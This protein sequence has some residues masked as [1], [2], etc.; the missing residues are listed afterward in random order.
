MVAEAGVASV[1]LQMSIL[2]FFALIGYLIAKRIGQSVVVGE[3]LVG[4]I[5]G[6][7]LLGWVEVT[8]LITSLAT[9]GAIFLLFVVGLET[10]FEEIKSLKNF[11]IAL[12]GVVV[13]WIGG[14]GF[15]LFFG[16]DLV[17]SIFVGTALTATSIAI[18]AHVLKEK[19]K[20]DSPAA[21]TIIGA[22]V[23]DDVLSLVGLSMTAQFAIQGTLDILFVVQSLLTAG[24]FIFLAYYI[25]SRFIAKYLEKT[26]VWATKHKLSKM[27]FIAAT[28]IALFYSV[29][30]ELV[31]LSAIV[32]AFIAGVALESL[33]IKSYREGAE[34][35][36]AIFASIFFVSLGILV[37]LNQASGVILFVVALVVV[38]IITKFIGGYVPARLFKMSKKDSTV[39]GIG[40]IPRG[41]IAMI[42][43]LIGLN[44]GLIGQEIYVAILMMGLLT[45]VVVPPLLERVYSS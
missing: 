39:V 27:T 45:T 15:S 6:P 2:L 40:L 23:I 7:S 12:F 32:G 13:P 10:K 34:Y 36:E 41:E 3:I 42:A 31:G 22:A 26:D 16:Y 17:S 35:L 18:T 11:V 20:L 38:A 24:I 8:S 1:E 5:I 37:D 9:I 33:K 4:I 43:G 19:K 21:K 14:F 30:A 44:A 28:T 25:G 29:L